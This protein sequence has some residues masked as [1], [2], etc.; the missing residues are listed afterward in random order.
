MRLC[1][2][3]A[4]LGVVAVLFLL[5]H[6]A[7][8]APFYF[9]YISDQRVITVQPI[10]ENELILNAIN[11]GDDVWVIH[12]YDVLLQSGLKTGLGHVFRREEKGAPGLFY[13]TQLIHPHQFAGVTVVG[14]LF[15]DP[16][17]VIFR[18][19]SRF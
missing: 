8:A 3:K 4:W 11:L 18:S 17:R 12:S 14:E 16:D 5:I 13:A 10:S 7:A 19:S 1:N 2:L 15:K 9:V 6:L